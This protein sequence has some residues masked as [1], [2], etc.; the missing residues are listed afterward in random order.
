M[1]GGTHLFSDTVTVTPCPPNADGIA[2]Y[3]VSVHLR[4]ARGTQSKSFRLSAPGSNYKRREGATHDSA[5]VVSGGVTYKV[6]LREGRYGTGSAAARMDEA[7]VQ[8][9]RL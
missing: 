3:S 4:L 2:P 7:V 8:V 9:S 1:P 6:I 5:R